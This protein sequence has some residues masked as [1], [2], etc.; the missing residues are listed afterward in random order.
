MA[1][2]TQFE[3]NWGLFFREW[4]TAD[5]RVVVQKIGIENFFQGP[6]GTSMYNFSESTPSG[7]SILSEWV[8]LSLT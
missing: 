4:C 2:S 8:G 6:A 3:Q 1:K 5:G 7:T